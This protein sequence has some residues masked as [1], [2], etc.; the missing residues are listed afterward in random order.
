MDSYNAG[1]IDIGFNR[2]CSSTSQAVTLS[3]PCR[4]AII[5]NNPVPVPM[6]KTC[7]YSPL[8]FISSIADFSASSYLTFCKINTI[9][10]YTIMS[11]EK[12]ISKTTE[13]VIHYNYL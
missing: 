1:S 12:S 9:I 3:A 11:Y 2:P 10:L 6:S 5:D 13:T 4:T 7:T 8:L